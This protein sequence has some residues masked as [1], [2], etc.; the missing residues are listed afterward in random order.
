MQEASDDSTVAFAIL[1]YQSLQEN[2]T[3]TLLHSLLFQ[4]IIDNKAL[5]P[6]LAYNYDSNNRKLLSSQKFVQELIKTLLIQLPI[7]FF[8]VDGLDEIV[9]SE[10]ETLLES[11]QTLQRESSNLRLL[12]SS[13]VEHDIDATFGA[14]CHRIYVHHWNSNDIA[15]YVTLRTTKWLAGL[16][17][18]PEV[19][20]GAQA[21]AKEISGRSEGAS[22]NP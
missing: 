6:V 4:I 2:I 1:S 9:E 21:C 18:S 5:R 19:I 13:R 8:V 20:T 10:R 3:L 15:E 22:L 11:L 14:E 7:V 17:L 16:K 12:I